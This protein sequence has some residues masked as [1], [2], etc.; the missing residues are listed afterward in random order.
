MLAGFVGADMDKLA[1]GK[2]LGDWQRHEA[3]RQTREN[4]ERMYDDYYVVQQAAPLY[5][6]MQVERPFQW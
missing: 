6:L 1:E 4:A 2:G 3:K 5:D